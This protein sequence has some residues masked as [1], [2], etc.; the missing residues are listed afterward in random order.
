MLA[1]DL[2]EE[3]LLHSAAP[4]LAEGL[5]EEELL[6]AMLPDSARA[7]PH[8]TAPVSGVTFQIVFTG[9]FVD[10]APV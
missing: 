2:D 6:P 1:E 8:M 5:E 4:M 3:E 10:V 7:S 9:A